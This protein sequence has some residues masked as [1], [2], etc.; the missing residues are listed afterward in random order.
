MFLQ[1][2]CAVQDLLMKMNFTLAV[3]PPFVHSMTSLPAMPTH[4]VWKYGF[5]SE[6]TSSGQ[7]QQLKV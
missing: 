6:P 7:I 4:S 2:Y 5:F 3:A 1:D